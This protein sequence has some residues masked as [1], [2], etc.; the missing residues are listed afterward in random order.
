VARRL[1][2]DTALLI[3]VERGHLPLDSAFAPDDDIV[4]AAVTIAEYVSGVHLARSQSQRARRQA[5]LD[6]LLLVTPVEDY[7]PVVAEH[8][9]ALLAHVRNT[10]KPR[11][12]HD[13][14]IAATA[15]ATDRT[16]VSTDA[17]AHFGEL[18]GVTAVLVPV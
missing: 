3:Q 17:H 12:A 8:H 16:L 11:G 9:G 18:P 5:F 1:I 4:I 13:L 14:I 10:G 7:T 15:R 6:E 2:L